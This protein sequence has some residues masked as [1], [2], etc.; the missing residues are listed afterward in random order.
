VT[1]VVSRPVIRQTGT[2]R[3]GGLVALIAVAAACSVGTDTQEGSNDLAP[4]EERDP[5]G[6]EVQ[7]TGPTLPQAPGNL[8]TDPGAAQEAIDAITAELGPLM[9]RSFDLYDQYAIFEVQDPTI[10][11]NL[12]TYTFRDGELEDPDPIHVTNRDLEELPNRLFSLADV[13]WDVVAQLS[14]TA[15][16]QLGIEDGVVNHMGVDRTYDTHELRLSLSVTGPRRSG[17]LEAT[18]DGTVLGTELF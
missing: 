1:R 3:L 7:T 15:V 13:R 17:S 2:A 5:D 6:P 4:A 18:A 16:A 12:D 11:E 8:L 14:Q 9:V 10:P